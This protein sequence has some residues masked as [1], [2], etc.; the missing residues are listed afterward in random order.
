VS[1]QAATLRQMSAEEHREYRA[2]R[3]TGENDARCDVFT[4]GDFAGE[5]AAFRQGYVDGWEEAREGMR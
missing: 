5:P 1:E 4:P 2:G 3:R